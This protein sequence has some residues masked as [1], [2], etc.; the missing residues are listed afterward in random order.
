[1]VE[2]LCKPGHLE[3]T[4]RE[5]EFFAVRLVDLGLNVKPRFLIREIQAVWSDSEKRIVWNVHCESLCC[6]LEDAQH[7]YAA[8]RAAIVAKGFNCPNL[9]PPPRRCFLILEAF[10]KNDRPNVPS[11]AQEP[12]LA[13]RNSFILVKLVKAERPAI[14]PQTRLQT[15]SLW[16]MSARDF[17]I[18]TSVF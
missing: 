14:V 15:S 13:P 8:R 2:I 9:A 6:T 17:A 1:M 16:A 12:I 18:A 11:L 4:A 5:T 7:H 10:S 3:S